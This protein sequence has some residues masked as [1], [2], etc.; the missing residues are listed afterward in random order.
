VSANRSQE[1][2][3]F[4]ALRLA[5]L[6]ILHLFVT[7]SA[8]DDAE[9]LESYTYAFEYQGQQVSSVRIGE[10]GGALSMAA[11]QKSFKAAIRALLRTMKDLPYLPGQ[12]IS[13]L[14]NFGYLTSDRTAQVGYERLIPVRLSPAVS[15]TWVWQC[16]RPYIESAGLA[17]ALAVAH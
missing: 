15:A 12:Y 3:V 13:L 8:S 5:Y 4:D 2:G 7:S 9:I 10:T 16:Q 14:A 6:D 1:D 11:S 17:Q